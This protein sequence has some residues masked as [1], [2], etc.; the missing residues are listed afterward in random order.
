MSLPGGDLYNGPL[1]L[2]AGL[3][4]A[5]SAWLAS[6]GLT[7][8]LM[9]GKGKDGAAVTGMLWGF[10]GAMLFEG[11]SFTLNTFKEYGMYVNGDP[12][13]KYILRTAAWGVSQ[14]LSGGFGLVSALYINKVQ[15]SPRFV[16]MIG[17]GSGALLSLLG[18]SLT[19]M[20]TPESLGLFQMHF[21]GYF[22]TIQILSLYGII[23]LFLDLP[24]VSAI[25]LAGFV[26]MVGLHFWQIAF[27]AFSVEMRSDTMLPIKL[28]ANIPILFLFTYGLVKVSEGHE[29][30]NQAADAAAA[31]S[32][33]KTTDTMTCYA[34]PE[35]FWGI[36]LVFLACGYGLSALCMLTITKPDMN[37]DPIYAM[38]E[39]Y[40]PCIL[41]D[42]LP[43]TL[44]AQ[45]L[46][47]LSVIMYQVCAVL[48][49]V[50]TSCAG[51]LSSMIHVALTAI[52]LIIFST[53]FELVFT[54]NPSKT[55]ALA[56]SIPFIG[57]QS[58]VAFFIISQ[59]AVVWNCV[60]SA[61]QPKHKWAFLAWGAFFAA[62]ELGGMGFMAVML[63]ENLGYGASAGKPGIAVDP[64][65]PIDNSDIVFNPLPFL[66][67]IAQIFN[68]W[69]FAIVNP[70]KFRP[71]VYDVS[72]LKAN[73]A[74]YGKVGDE[75]GVK[76]RFKLQVS[77]RVFLRAGVVMMVLVIF[78]AAFVNY[79]VLGLDAIWEFGMLDHLRVMPG[80]VVGAV[81]WV[82]C[83]VFFG[84]HILTVCVF[85]EM[86]NP[87][88]AS[89]IG[90]WAAG[91]ALFVCALLA[92][93]ATIP[94]VETDY[95][96]FLGAEAFQVALAIWIGV[97]M[98]LSYSD[99]GGSTLDTLLGG[100]TIVLLFYSVVSGLDGTGN[101][102][103]DTLWT[104]LLF[105]W[106]FTDPRECGL[107]VNDIHIATD[108]EVVAV[109]DEPSILVPFFMMDLGGIKA[110]IKQGSS[111]VSA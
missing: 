67:A 72:A 104:V 47:D 105:A 10:A 84:L 83:A 39:T 16:W 64:N 57:N 38:Y 99:G 19:L 35:W 75:G 24:N 3:S 44:F 82:V 71:L 86:K 45:P 42:Y 11:I 108:P 43:G 46:F 49:F 22:E 28:F 102:F 55:S 32:Q 6:I 17:I 33:R 41:L 15:L 111:D 58:S 37:T 9:F 74:G 68:Q 85:E 70:L 51:D 110:A 66:L 20:A 63:L 78:L 61:I 53:I 106:S 21:L 30:L 34:S 12:P 1:E 77:T 18:A 62:V 23:K 94:G 14:C 7:A 73:D 101:I 87:L 100:V 95:S 92:H 65:A 81:G 103:V 4:W 13:D 56:H 2:T 5:G 80:S 26:G 8:Y 76:G 96:W 40:H 60:D 27:T 97:N 107:L 89:V 69:L 29:V 54:F 50:R 109:M 79:A 88:W 52:L 93:A 91:A 98:R 90:T 59:A 25:A 48:A 36:T 31:I